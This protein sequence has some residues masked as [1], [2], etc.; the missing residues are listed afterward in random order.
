MEYKVESTP[1][2]DQDLESIVSYIAEDLDNLAAATRFLDE[3]DAWI[4]PTR[5]E[6]SMGC[7]LSPWMTT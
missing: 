7:S 5:L 1:S 2:A 4:S 6:V 3:V